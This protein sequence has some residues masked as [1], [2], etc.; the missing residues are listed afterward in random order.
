MHHVCYATTVSQP[1]WD[2]RLRWVNLGIISFLR[3][4]FGFSTCSFL[5]YVHWLDIVHVFPTLFL[6]VYSS[7]PLPTTERLC[8]GRGGG[9]KINDNPPSPARCK[10]KPVLYFR[11]RDPVFSIHR[12][13]TIVKEVRK[14]FTLSI[15]LLNFYFDK[16]ILSFCLWVCPYGY[17]YFLKT[18]AWASFF[19]SLPSYPK[20]MYLYFN[21]T[22]EGFA[23]EFTPVFLRF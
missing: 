6:S 13:R 11:S 19:L 21:L 16:Q 3:F 18:T 10:M 14:L 4:S 5:F 2:T 22:L 12:G 23:S 9:W 1:Q 20:T 17:V 8:W 15:F 7:T